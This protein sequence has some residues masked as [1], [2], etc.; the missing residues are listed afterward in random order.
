[1]E[2]DKKTDQKKFSGF[3]LTYFDYMIAKV[4]YFVY[5]DI[6]KRYTCCDDNYAT[7]F[8][9]PSQSKLSYQNP[10]IGFYYNTV[11]GGF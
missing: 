7:P 5:P 2:R 1:M 3:Y 9:F 11:E 8:E 4:D 6:S 10:L